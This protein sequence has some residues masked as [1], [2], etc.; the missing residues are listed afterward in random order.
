LSWI[1]QSHDLTG[2]RIQDC[3]PITLVSVTEQA[4]EPEVRFLCRAA[5]RLWNNMV[6]HHRCADDSLLRQA[7]AAPAAR[8]SSN[9][10]A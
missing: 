6:D 4:C 9:E 10:I 3:D 5:Q 7:V 1:E 8:G 2:I